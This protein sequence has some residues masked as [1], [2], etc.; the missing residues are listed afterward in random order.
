MKH[1]RERFGA[2]AYL[3]CSLLLAATLLLC[4]CAGS[5]AI[6]LSDTVAA[7]AAALR[8]VQPPEG[9][10]GAIILSVRLPRVLCVA[11]TGAS[12]SLC[13]AAMQGL[14]VEAETGP[15]I[16]PSRRCRRPAC[17]AWSPA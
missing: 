17:G 16:R 10:A 9:V 1:T 13:G 8:G 5:V 4:V 12:L 7:I 14:P 3:L 6:P 2:A 15:P 11:L